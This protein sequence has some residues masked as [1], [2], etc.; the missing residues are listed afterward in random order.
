MD[1][2][3]TE[4]L[5]VG[6]REGL[7]ALATLLLG[8]AWA[9]GS[10]QER[11]LGPAMV[12]SL[13]SALV[14]ARLTHWLPWEPM[15]PG[16]SEKVGA[17]WSWVLGLG[18]LAVMA[19]APG[20]RPSPGPWVR[21]AVFAAGVACFLP[22]LSDAMAF[23][24][25]LVLRDGQPAEVA[26][27][28]ATGFMLPL[29]WLRWGRDRMAS[30]RFSPS[31]GALLSLLALTGLRGTGP[32]W[33]R[34]PSLWAGAVGLVEHLTAELFAFL[35]IP[36]ATLLR[37]SPGRLLAP[38]GDAAFPTLVVAALA[39][40]GLVR[41]VRLP[42]TVAT[43]EAC[44]PT[45]RAALEGRPRW[46]QVARWLRLSTSPALFAALAG[47]ATLGCVSLHLW[48]GDAR[49]WLFH[50]PAARPLLLGGGGLLLLSATSRVVQAARQ[51][52]RDG[53][54]AA[55][56]W[57]VAPLG[58]L[59]AGGAWLGSAATFERHAAHLMTDDTVSVPWEDGVYQLE[60]MD[61]GLR[62]EVL[63]P[64]PGEASLLVREPTVTLSSAA[65]RAA[66]GVFP[67]AALG[68]TFWH[69]SD[70]GLAPGVRIRNAHGPHVEG[71]FMVEVLPPGRVGTFRIPNAPYLFELVLAAGAPPD[72]DR[73][74]PLA[75]NLRQPTYDVTVRWGDAW[76]VQGSSAGATRFDGL[77]MTFVQSEHWVRLEAGRNPFRLP[78]AAGLLM[79]LSGLPLG[80]A[81]A[82]MRRWSG[83][84]RAAG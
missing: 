3:I 44:T 39:L 61:L 69:I 26:L 32:S 10:G 75:C 2:I 22:G 13:A 82:G 30:L 57:A 8:R 47:A 45:C 76:K 27:S 4:A 78:L 42:W 83:R 46:R 20:A 65:G 54:V 79:V 51:R 5:Q 34:L 21:W 74:R 56:L 73:S 58:A 11:A 52:W 31:L 49:D 67:P 7:S 64:A 29:L 68:E 60:Q 17:Q 72:S 23:L 36:P 28:A 80:L 37:A 71:H 48:H 16:L 35:M 81:G 15:T 25:A 59:L 9:R 43:A 77:T 70:V 50:A 40:A 84:V 1:L 55:A 33:T 6:L 62:E 12:A 66:V 63:L 19:R 18:G 41:A 38:L 24:D 14:L 53:W